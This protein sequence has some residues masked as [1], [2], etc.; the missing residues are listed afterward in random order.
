MAKLNPDLP[1]S[2]D[3]SYLNY[4][5][6]IPQPEGIST[7]ATMFKGLANTVG[8][9]GKAAEFLEKS[10]IDSDVA[11]AQVLRDKLI[12]QLEDRLA[13]TPTVAGGVTDENGNAILPPNS[14]PV[15]GDAAA[16]GIPIPKPRPSTDVVQPTQP[17]QPLPPEVAGVGERAEKLYNARANN[18]IGLG[19]Y[20]ME[21]DKM[22]KSIRNRYPG[23]ERYVDAKISAVTGGDPANKRITDV[24]ASIN[25]QQTAARTRVDKALATLR[26]QE[27]LKVPGTPNVIRYIENGGDPNLAYDWINSAKFK[28]YRNEQYKLDLEYVKMNRE[29]MEIKARTFATQDATSEASLYFSSVMLN[30]GLSTPQQLT[31]YMRK[32]ATGELKP[33]PA[34]AEQA[35]MQI[36]AAEN[37]VR[38]TLWKRWSEV[39]KNGLSMIDKLG[40]PEKAGKLLDESMTL[41][42]NSKSLISAGNYDI[43]GYNARMNKAMIDNGQHVLLTGNGDPNLSNV[44]MFNTALAAAIKLHGPD[45]AKLVFQDQ[46]LQ[47][48]GLTSLEQAWTGTAILSYLAPPADI[49][50]Q[51]NLP[52]DLRKQGWQPNTQPPAPFP[53][54]NDTVKRAQDANN[55]APGTV[56]PQAVNNVIDITKTIGSTDKNVPDSAR[57][58]IARAAFNPN[59]RNFLQRF[60]KDTTDEKG[61]VIPGRWDVWSRMMNPAITRQMARLGENDPQLRRWYL[62]W[63]TQSFAFDL[64]NREIHDLNDIQMQPNMR[65]IWKSDTKQFELKILPKQKNP[66]DPS[67]SINEPEYKSIQDAQNSVRN[68]NKGLDSFKHLAEA[69]GINVDAFLLG[70][71]M[72]AGY[73]PDDNTTKTFPIAIA[74]ALAASKEKAQGVNAPK[75][76]KTGPR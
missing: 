21:M 10:S 57:Y 76:G 3:P 27:M 15:E 25:A 61:N 74:K 63:A 54:I 42:K 8:E 43:A 71:M 12:T 4:S 39:D 69:E 68:L 33:D 52:D 11:E 41:F 56:S 7:S 72:D 45:Y 28:D 31:D 2:N 29:G 26:T 67:I 73:R 6:Q 37:V 44:A 51:E 35:G 50:R 14:S 5:K 64:F 47:A 66:N 24:I 13:N 62:D 34:L 55:I 46:L 18:K 48:S 70:N 58:A 36:H 23:M 60:I 59:N 38:E 30:A 32:V 49:R 22:A 9:F 17:T 75:Y 53:S 1:K 20:Y 16:A 65:L 40:G 19:E